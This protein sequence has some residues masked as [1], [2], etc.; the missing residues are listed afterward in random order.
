M[1][2]RVIYGLAVIIGIIVI[3]IAIFAHSLGLSHTSGLDTRKIILLIVGIV[4]LL[5]GL[6]GVSTSRA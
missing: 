2:N 4:V 1:S 6:W 3:V 5:L